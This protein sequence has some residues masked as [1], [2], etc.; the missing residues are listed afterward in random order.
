MGG[1]IDPAEKEKS[2]STARIKR[3]GELV[4]KVGNC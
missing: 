1:V 3:K 2:R 4:P